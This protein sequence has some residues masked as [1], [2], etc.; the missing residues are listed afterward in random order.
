MPGDSDR[1]ARRPL[2]RPLPLTTACP[3]AD[4]L[5]HHLGEPAADRGPVPVGSQLRGLPSHARHGLP[6]GQEIA[7]SRAQNSRV[8]VWHQQPCAVGQQLDRMGERGGDDRFGG[9][10]RL[11]EDAGIGLLFVGMLALGVVIISRTSSYSGGLTEILF[12]NALAATRRDIIVLAGA[13]VAVMAATAIFYRPF[14]V[15]SF[16]SDKA[17]MLGLHPRAAHVIMLTLVTL[18]VV[19]SF[20]TVGSLLVFGLLVA[21]PA[22]ASLVAR[23]VPVMMTVGAGLGAAAVVIGLLVSWHADTAA[24]ATIAAIAV[25]TFFVVLALRPVLRG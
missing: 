16:N 3:L 14:L 6:I 8:V 20:Q 1:V 10:Y 13:L 9:G 15:L 21:P 4:E 5:R 2:D 25:A 11:H 7:Q 24:S 18:A 17:E 19:T 12:G 23:R 22:A